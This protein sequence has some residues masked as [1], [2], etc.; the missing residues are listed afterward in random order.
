MV[1]MPILYALSAYGMAIL[2][3]NSGTYPS[4]S[5]TLS[6]IYRGDVLYRAICNGDYWPVFDPHWYNGAELM[7][8]M[9]PLPTYLFAFCQFLGGG[10]AMTGFLIFVAFI[11]F[12]GAVVWLYIGFKVN[13]PYFG[14]FLGFLWFFIPNNLIT[15]FYEGDLPRS[16]CIAVLPLLMYWV[17]DYLREQHW[18]TIPKL[19]L[20]FAMIA[21][22]E[23]GYALLVMIACMIYFV[24]D[25]IIYHKWHRDVQAFFA[26]VLGYFLIGLWLVPVIKGDVTGID[27]LEI[28]ADFFQSMFLSVNPFARLQRGNVDVYFG[29]AAMLLAIF[30]ILLS[31][32]KSMPGFWTGILILVCSSETLYILLSSLPGGDILL[33]LRFVSIGL[34]MILFSFLIWETLKKGWILLFAVLLIL[35]IVP[36]MPLILGGQTGNPPEVRLNSYAEK[37]LVREAKGMTKQRLALVDESSLGGLSSYLITGYE[38]AVATTYG[39]AEETAATVN[40]FKQID[41]ALEE[42]HYL[43]VFD[44]CLEMGNDTVVIQLDIVGDLAKN[45][46]LQMDHAALRVG[47]EL[48]DYNDNYRF[49]KLNK[50]GIDGNWGTITKYRAIG[51]GTAAPGISRQFPIVEETDTTNLNDFTFEELKEYDLIYLSGFTYD[52]KEKAEKMIEDLSEAGVRI[53]I[54]ADG[55]PDDRGSQNQ[56]FLGVI[57]NGVSFSQGYPNLDTIDGMLETDLFPNGYRDWS[58]VY[59][60]GLD[61]V[62]GTV[63]DLDWNLPFFGTVK[64][65][66]III[67]GLNLTYYYG[68]TLD[69][70]VG[71]LL[72]R[73]MNISSTELPEREIVPYAVQYGTDHITIQADRD[74]V[75]TGLAYH[76]SFTASQ[77]IYMKN[78]L[79]YVGAGTTEISIGYPYLTYGIAVSGGAFVLLIGY[80]VY[81]HG[82]LQKKEKKSENQSERKSGVK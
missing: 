9:A 32:K 21:L 12:T 43:Y 42:G 25:M 70:G 15:L 71:A 49:Y 60:D 6:H 27:N 33:M 58:T 10:S 11:F 65:D 20:C 45:P 73:A 78:H 59:V 81:I 69:E 4:G 37:T 2:V 56:S 22:C 68:L 66:N 48:V 51:I 75:N 38:E 3:Q 39:G 8:Y 47:Y 54:A 53:V 24:I 5:D 13:R 63:K 26:L 61:E 74:D 29:L 67:I 80:T 46:V 18:Y 34:C 57:C 41:R 79:T 19:S 7:R 23:P 30:G 64:N 17:Y 82:R 35:D 14:A 72:D 28:M 40:N 16:I 31:K 76:N 1:L 44:R 62:W 77:E 50:K 36:S 52:D 55:I